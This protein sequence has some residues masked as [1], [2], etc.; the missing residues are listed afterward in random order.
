MIGRAEANGSST[1]IS[2]NNAPHASS[3]R[4]GPST[5]PRYT[6]NGPMNI[7]AALNDVLSQEASSTLR[8][9]AP[10]KSA[11][12]TLS[13]RPV[14]V[15]IIAPSSTPR[16]PN[17]GW[18]VTAEETAADAVGVVEAE[19]VLKIEGP[20]HSHS[21]QRPS[22]KHARLP[23]RTVPAATCPATD[24][25]DPAQSLPVFAARP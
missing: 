15:A 7:I 18:V 23:P 12:P 9:K 20:P 8:C 11:R 25:P 4:R 13:K 2:V 14:L 5:P 19:G 16:T 10:R 6:E 17:I 3:T 21:C 22:P 1:L 24:V